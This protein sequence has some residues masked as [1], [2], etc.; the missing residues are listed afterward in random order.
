MLSFLSSWY[1][2]FWNS[3]E[4]R[5]DTCITE[6][7]GCCTVSFIK[8]SY[9][10]I[11]PILHHDW[12]NCF[13]TRNDGVIGYWR[14]DQIHA[15]W[16]VLDVALFLLWVFLDELL[17]SVYSNTV[18]ERAQDWYG[19]SY[20]NHC[21]ELF[22]RILCPFEHRTNHYEVLQIRT[23]GCSWYYMHHAMY[24]MLHRFIHRM[25]WDIQVPRNQT[26]VTTVPQIRTFEC[27]HRCLLGEL[28]RHIGVTIRECSE[29]EL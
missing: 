18:L 23:F 16:N 15:S 19:I 29:A 4:E 27:S 22:I 8:C 17:W 26:H 3:L 5:S 10:S 1:L 12:T 11:Q 6:C 20:T 7:I 25:F 13:D 21:D 24:W 9:K 2:F 28:W 14:M